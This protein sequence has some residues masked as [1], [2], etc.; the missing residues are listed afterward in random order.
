MRTIP[1]MV[2]DNSYSPSLQ[3]HSCVQ[4][5]LSCH[6][7]LIT[8]VASDFRRAIMDS[9]FRLV[10]LNPCFKE[11]EALALH[12]SSSQTHPSWPRNCASSRKL[13]LQACT[14]G[15][16][17]IYTLESENVFILLD[18]ESRPNIVDLVYNFTSMDYES[19]SNTMNNNPELLL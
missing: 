11:I 6:S 17:L 8:S 4:S 7:D 9:S 15:L 18:A 13:R 12:K 3:V 14:C 19:S 10:P 1:S 16:I 5:F 2:L